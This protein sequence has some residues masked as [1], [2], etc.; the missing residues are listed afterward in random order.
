MGSFGR[1][2]HRGLRV[3]SRSHRATFCGSAMQP[4][5][6]SGSSC[7]CSEATPS[8]WP[9]GSAPA[10][11]VSR[12]RSSPKCALREFVRCVKLMLLDLVLCLPL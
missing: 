12:G 5:N 4:K 11:S 6:G 8:A 3:R 7:R 9:F 10:S 2:P 1:A